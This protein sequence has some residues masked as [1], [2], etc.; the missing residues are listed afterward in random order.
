MKILKIWSTIFIN[1]NSVNCILLHKFSL[2]YTIL[3]LFSN[4][5][6]ISTKKFKT[7]KKCSGHTKFS[8]GTTTRAGAVVRRPLNVKGWGEE[9]FNASFQ[10]LSCCKDLPFIS[11]ESIK[12]KSSYTTMSDWKKLSSKPAYKILGKKIY[13]NK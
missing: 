6:Y 10:L 9:A 5:F 3:A 1:K 7:F 4:F 12:P 13:N 2:F 8:Q 11:V